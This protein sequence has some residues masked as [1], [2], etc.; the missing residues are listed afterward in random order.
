MALALY[1]LFNDYFE[2]R[3]AA[4]IRP[5]IPDLSGP[6][7]FVGLPFSIPFLGDELHLLPFLMLGMTFLQQKVSQTPGAQTSSQS[8]MLLYGMP[9]F[10]FFIMYNMPSGLLLYWTMQSLISFVQ[11]F[12]INHLKQKPQQ[13]T[14]A[15][16]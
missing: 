6:E 15:K 13:G 7:Q 11:Q 9:L 14:G 2:L 12:Y 16:G 3:G 10:F 1:R 5:W 4:F 8:K